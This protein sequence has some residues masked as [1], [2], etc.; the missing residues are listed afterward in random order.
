MKIICELIQAKDSFIKELR[1]KLLFLEQ[2]KITKILRLMRKSW[3]LR[4]KNMQK[5]IGSVRKE[6][7]CFMAH[8]MKKLV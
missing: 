3:E 8:S 7:Q 2:E 1:T 4:Q 6:F 5:Q